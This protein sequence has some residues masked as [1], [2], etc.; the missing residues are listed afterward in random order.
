MDRDNKRPRVPLEGW[1]GAIIFAAMIL[2][3]AFA[4][5]PKS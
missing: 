1:L 3:L 5:G 2:L 4:S